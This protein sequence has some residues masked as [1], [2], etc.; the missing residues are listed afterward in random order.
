MSN[1]PVR[2]INFNYS[3]YNQRARRTISVS[4]IRSTGVAFAVG[5]RRSADDWLWKGDDHNRRISWATPTVINVQLLLTCINSIGPGPSRR[6]FDVNSP[7]GV[8]EG[9][10]NANY[11]TV[12]GRDAAR[13]RGRRTGSP[14]NYWPN[15]SVRNT[16]SNSGRQAFDWL[17]AEIANASSILD[18]SKALR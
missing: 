1:E 6:M 14:A 3:Q 15:R 10:G 13:G 8:A 9:I 2:S 17:R 7:V 5:N 18:T 4:A 11:S 16:D 12:V